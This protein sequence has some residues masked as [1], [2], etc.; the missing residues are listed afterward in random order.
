[1]QKFSIKVHKGRMW[2][3]DGFIVKKNCLQENMQSTK[4]CKVANMALSKKDEKTTQ[5]DLLV[6]NVSEKGVHLH[7][8]AHQFLPNYS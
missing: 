8:F 2:A 4:I 7:V 3:Q 6:D 5:V 1:M